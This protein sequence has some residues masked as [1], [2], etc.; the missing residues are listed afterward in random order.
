MSEF[1]E[2][3]NE[4]FVQYEDEYNKNANPGDPVLYP[5]TFKIKDVCGM[6]KSMRFVAIM[7]IILGALSCLSSVGIVSGVLTI[8][9][10][11]KLKTAAETV[12]TVGYGMNSYREELLGEDLLGFFKYNGIVW[13]L[14]IVSTVFSV[15]NIVSMVGSII[16]NLPV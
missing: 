13:I 14:S 15:V 16:E 1:S 6:A 5:L 10:G 3:K 7:T 4:N 8:I 2:D 9:A 12:E 11:V